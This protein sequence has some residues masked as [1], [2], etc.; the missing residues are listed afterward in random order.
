MK[1][2]FLG[3]SVQTARVSN[4]TQ[5]RHSFYGDEAPNTEDE[6]ADF[7]GEGENNKGM[8][9]N[10]D[11]LD[12]TE[13]DPDFYRPSLKHDKIVEGKYEAKGR[14]IKNPRRGQ[15][16]VMKVYAYYLPNPEGKGNYYVTCT[17][18]ESKSKPNIITDAFFALKDHQVA[19]H[20]ATAKRHFSRKIFWYSL[21][22]IMD[23][24]QQ[25]ELNNKIKIFRYGDAVN[26]LIEKEEKA[27]VIVNHPKN[28]VDFQLVIQEK[29]TENGK[30]P[31]YEFSFFERKEQPISLDSGKTRVNWEADK[32]ALA[33]HCRDNSPNL[34][35]KVQHVP[36]SND[37]EKKVIKTVRGLID[38]DALFGKIYK[39]LYKTEY[40]FSSAGDKAS[41]QSNDGGNTNNQSADT[42]TANDANLVS[43]EDIPTID[44][45]KEKQNLSIVQEQVVETPV[46]N[47]P[48]AEPL[49]A[50][51]EVEL[52][53]DK[54]GELQISNEINYDDI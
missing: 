51:K 31:T 49:I 17:S 20:R 48:G 27:G 33:I 14:F 29:S 39:N 26:K 6:F 28:G 23:D 25:P 2:T 19:A 32:M 45:E 40:D 35:E 5:N 21:Y 37:L 41:F 44:D 3:F 4:T 30:F 9:S 7:F 15:P 42:M 34:V 18:N 12:A 10:E 36:W 43:I 38:D 8:T 54:A 50:M 22:Q 16:D 47:G 1:K 52:P 46:T 53:I 13:V 11:E 24:R